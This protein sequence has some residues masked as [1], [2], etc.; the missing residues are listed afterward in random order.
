[1]IVRTIA[2]LIAVLNSNGRPFEVGA[3]IACG[4]LLALVPG[5]SAL[6]LA[7]LIIIFFVKINL[8]MT[9]AFYLLFALLAPV[10]DGVLDALGYW[11]L[12]RPALESLFSRLEHT[13]IV[14]ITRFSNTIVMGGFVAG[15]LLW[16]PVAFLSV[17]LVN[18]YRHHSHARIAG[19][20]LVKAYMAT[21]LA[22]RIAAA[23]RRLKSVWPAAG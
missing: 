4:L 1:M 11:I 19:S 5:R 20:K 12:T 18:L 6:F 3:G 15:V 21:P 17:V 10:V 23:L 14:P 8:G 7:I 2:R 13:P 16:G 9:I 22:Q